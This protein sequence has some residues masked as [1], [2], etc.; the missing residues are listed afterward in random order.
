MGFAKVWCPGSL[1][2]AEGRAV[3]QLIGP[4]LGSTSG[5]PPGL[6]SSLGQAAADSG[7]EGGT[8]QGL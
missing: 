6:R 2:Q 1:A 5:Q 7:P 4:R 8:P 3:S